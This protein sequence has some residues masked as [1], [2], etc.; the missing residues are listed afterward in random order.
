MT[1][2]DRVIIAI[3]VVVVLCLGG[4]SAFFFIADPFGTPASSNSSRDED[5]DDEEADGEE[6]EDEEPVDDLTLSLDD[7]ASLSDYASVD[8]IDFAPQA[9]QFLLSEAVTGID[10]SWGDFPHEGCYGAY[11]ITSLVGVD[12]DANSSERLTSITGYDSPLSDFSDGYVSAFGRVL[13]SAEDAEDLLAQFEDAAAQCDDGFAIQRPDGFL[14]VGATEYAEADYSVPASVHAMTLA[15][16]VNG[17]DDI[18]GF[19]INVLQRGNAVIA[20]FAIVTPSSPFDEYAADELA[21]AVAT[22]LGDF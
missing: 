10:S 17:S 2:A 7:L 9:S 20:T 1:R 12:D 21:E 6:D 16:A 3:T 8:G 19:R 14:S 4:L 13:D 15:F 5:E 11:A 22:G 18:T